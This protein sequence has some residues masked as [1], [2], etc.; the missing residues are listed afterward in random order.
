MVWLIVNA[1]S[2]V[3]DKIRNS[4]KQDKEKEVKGIKEREC[5]LSGKPIESNGTDA[6]GYGYPTKDDLQ[7]S[8]NGQ[9]VSND[10]GPVCR[11]GGGGWG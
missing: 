4:G 5:V 1:C 9:V 11:R 3:V 8:Q 2:W 7:Y 6:K 10:D